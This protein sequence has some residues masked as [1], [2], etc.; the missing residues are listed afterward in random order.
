MKKLCP[1]FI[2]LALVLLST[3]GDAFAAEP[4]VGK[5]TE[6]VPR[7]AAKRD[8][9]EVPLTAGAEIYEKD[10]LVT[11]AGG[12]IEVTFQDGTLLSVGPQSEVD[13][14]EFVMSDAKNEFRSELIKGAAR[15]VTGGLVR[16]NPGGFKI[17]TPRSTIGIRGTTVLC[18]FR[19]GDEIIAVESLGDGAVRGGHVTVIDRTSGDSMRIDE[20]GLAFVRR[21]GGK[22]SVARLDDRKRA[23]VD[24]LAGYTQPRTV[25]GGAKIF[26]DLVDTVL[27]N[28]VEAQPP[29]APT[30]SAPSTRVTPRSPS[31]RSGILDGGDVERRDVDHSGERRERIGGGSGNIE[32]PS[33]REEPGEVCP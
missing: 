3:V 17:G 25:D 11:D 15:V 23:A 32:P 22:G 18:I 2:L 8:G 27:E 20:A 12:R 28:P 21:R 33:P 29:S 30:P 10:A 7:S 13:I 24:A 16:R 31:L 9:R 14:R 1:V 26:N 5:V 4:A 19:G 6:L